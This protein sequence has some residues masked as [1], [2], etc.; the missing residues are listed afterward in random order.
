MNLL[1]K[2][3]K[4]Y[5]LLGVVIYLKLK[6][7]LA[8]KMSLPRITYPISLRKATSDPLIFSQVFGH[9][10]Y[11]IHLSFIPRVIL[12]LGANI[13]LA[14]VYFANKY[15]SSKIIAVEPEESNFSLLLDNT[16]NYKNIVPL[17]NAVSDQSNKHVEI[18]NKGYGNWG[19]MTQLKEESEDSKSVVK[20][21]TIKET[22][23]TY[24]LASIDILK[25]DIEGAEKELF[26][27]NFESWMPIT[28]CIIVELHDNMK[29]GCSKAFFTCISKYNF[30][31]SMRGE[32][33]IMINEDLAEVQ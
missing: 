2:Y 6:L 1:L 26:E 32:N 29:R 16:K 20:T 11:E 15:P 9:L 33:L 28:K 30:S 31:F 18:V 25:V 22:V 4:I 21:I 24:N 12:D 5:K 3:I 27:G 17:Q 7:G 19:F 8:T 10:E 13:G 14:S 23:D